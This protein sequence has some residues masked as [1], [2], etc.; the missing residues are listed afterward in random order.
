MEFIKIQRIWRYEVELVK[1]KLK[2]RM[3]VHKYG[4]SPKSTKQWN[5]YCRV[6]VTNDH[7]RVGTRFQY[8]R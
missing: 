2:K 5:Q 8:F 6:S 4:A 3:D 7:V 1:F